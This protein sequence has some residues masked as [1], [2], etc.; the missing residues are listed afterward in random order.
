MGME[1]KQKKLYRVAKPFGSYRT[2][3]IIEPTGLLRSDWLRRGLIEEFFVDA[4]HA[5]EPHP[6]PDTGEFLD[7][8]TEETATIE[9]NAET[10]QAPRRGRGRPRKVQ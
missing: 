6:E 3:R 4:P 10:T 1:V 8:D 5:P 9:D 7:D 2:G